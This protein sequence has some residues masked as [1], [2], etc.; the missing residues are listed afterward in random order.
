MLDLSYVNG[1]LDYRY[2]EDWDLT[3]PLTKLGY[4]T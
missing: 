3:T 1:W 4:D 2:E